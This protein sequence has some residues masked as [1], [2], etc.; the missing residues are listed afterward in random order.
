M[1]RGT[2]PT[3][4][5]NVN[6]EYDM[7]DVVQ[8]WVTLKNPRNTISY[9]KTF[10]IDHCVIDTTNNT[11]TIGLT[12]QDTLDIKG[13]DY[14]EAQIRFLKQNGMASASDIVK[15]EVNRILKDGVITNE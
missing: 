1:Y 14:F 10:D 15:L 11:I 2:T 13:L 4:V 9:E 7:T 12:Q 5:F 8:L 3:I 6:E